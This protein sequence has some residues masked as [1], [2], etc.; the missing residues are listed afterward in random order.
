MALTVTG[1]ITITYGGGAAG[2][3]STTQAALAAGFVIPTMPAGGI[4]TFTAPVNITGTATQSNT[5]T[6]TAPSGISDPSPGNNTSTATTNPGPPLATDL[7]IFKQMPNDFHQNGS[8]TGDI[9]LTVT[10][11]GPDPA[12]GAIVKEALDPAL[13]SNGPIA[14][15]YNAGASG[16][17][18]TTRANLA[19][20]FVIPVFPSGGN[21]FFIIPVKF[22]GNVDIYNQAT[23]D[24]P[25]GVTETN[26]PNNFSSRTAIAIAPP[27]PPTPPGTGCAT[28][29]PPPASQAAAELIGVSTLGQQIFGSVNGGQT[30]SISSN[31]GNASGTC[32]ETSNGASIEVTIFTSFGNY[33][34]RIDITGQRF[35]DNAASLSTAYTWPTQAQLTALGLGTGNSAIVVVD[36]CITCDDLSGASIHASS[37]SFTYVP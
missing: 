26:P 14:I 33:V 6:V 7:S 1:P 9:K 36:R 22:T 21:A 37:P 18:T 23:V 29:F 2:P 28:I 5:A 4:A 31:W 17:A 25:A 13:V 12:D 19:S 11:L 3:A 34:E 10:N 8:D 27:P 20:G 15:T 16:P 24:T 32:R 35:N 30:D